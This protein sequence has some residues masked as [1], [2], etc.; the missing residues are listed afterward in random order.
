MKELTKVLI[1]TAVLII[2]I[3]G[4]F[5]AWQKGLLSKNPFSLAI[6]NQ[7]ETANWKTYSNKEVGFEI[8]YPREFGVYIKNTP[9]SFITAPDDFKVGTNEEIYIA[10]PNDIAL[11]ESKKDQFAVINTS[12]RIYKFGINPWNSLEEFA[13][14]EKELDDATVKMYGDDTL[15]AIFKN[16]MINDQPALEITDKNNH[17]AYFIKDGIVYGLAIYADLLLEDAKL[18][19]NIIS[20]FKFLK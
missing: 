6:K 20:T 15:R 4:G 12:V 18:L 17:E 7:D 8:Q 16:L 13:E 9:T 10:K 3:G 14:Q 11:F 1:A 19:K 5:L 2:L